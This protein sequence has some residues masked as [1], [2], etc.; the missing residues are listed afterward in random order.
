MEK[1]IVYVVTENAVT[2]HSDETHS[3][4][5]VFETIES[6]REYIEECKLSVKKSWA[7]E[8]ED[9]DDWEE[10]EE[11]N[12]YTLYRSDYEYY[13]RVEIHERIVRK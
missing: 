1:K 13:Y 8:M 10:E 12:D 5:D 4:L 6:A 11:E 9:E 2:K 7:D 3:V